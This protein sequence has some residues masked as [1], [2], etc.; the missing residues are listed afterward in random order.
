M[1]AEVFVKSLEKCKLVSRLL[2]QSVENLDDSDCP[3]IQDLICAQEGRNVSRIC[4]NYTFRR[5]SRLHCAERK[6]KETCM[7]NGLCN[8]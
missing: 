7:E 1:N 4:S 8:I 2:G 6:G 3:K 5:K